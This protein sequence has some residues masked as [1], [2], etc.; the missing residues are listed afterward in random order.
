MAATRAADERADRME[1]AKRAAEVRPL[2]AAVAVSEVMVVVASKVAAGRVA[3][4]K[5]MAALEMVVAVEHWATEAAAAMVRATKV[6]MHVQSASRCCLRRTTHWCAPCEW[7]S[8]RT[9]HTHC[10]VPTS[11]APKS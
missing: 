7:Y 1:A 4:E 3:V 10:L 5:V 9:L 11:P 6:V 2:A 8:H